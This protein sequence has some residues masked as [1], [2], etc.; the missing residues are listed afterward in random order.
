MKKDTGETVWDRQVA[1]PPSARRMTL[2]PL[3]I[4]DVAIVGAA[5]RS[6]GFAAGSM[7]P[8]SIPAS[9]FG[10]PTLCR[11]KAK[12]VT[13]PGRIT[14]TRREHGGG[15]V[16]ET[17]TYDAATDT[18]FPGHRQSWSRT[19]MRNIAR[20]IISGPTAHGDGPGDRQSE[21]GVPV[22]CRTIRS[23][24]TRSANIRWSTCHQRP[25]AQAG[26][27]RWAQRI[28]L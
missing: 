5:G 11:R 10:A 13:T 15:S 23:T 20:A 2:A 16:W 28:L 8:I 9:R 24:M 1:N 19:G 12:R 27:A 4:R 25:A 17:G 6:M 22:H 21:M 26:G 14:T 3:V 18:M 7:R